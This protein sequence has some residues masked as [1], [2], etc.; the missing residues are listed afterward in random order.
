MKI[1]YFIVFIALWALAMPLS[2]YSSEQNQQQ[3]QPCP[4][5]GKA[6]PRLQCYER[7]KSMDTNHDGAVTLEE[8]ITIQHHRGYP[9]K[10]F[11]SKDINK[12]GSLTQEELCAG[13]GMH[14]RMGN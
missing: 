9:E 12:D 10:I 4:A 3:V 8:F 7:F 1:K 14:K 5:G 13:K 6:T 2:A 11:K